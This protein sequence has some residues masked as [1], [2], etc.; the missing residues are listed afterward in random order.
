[1]FIV[2]IRCKELKKKNEERSF[3]FKSIIFLLFEIDAFK[4]D[5]LSGCL[6]WKTVG[7]TVGWIGLAM[8]IALATFFMSLFWLLNGEGF[9]A[10]TLLIFCK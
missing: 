1:M 2:D 9:L 6:T 7:K 10:F 5:R 8:N 4:M 3:S